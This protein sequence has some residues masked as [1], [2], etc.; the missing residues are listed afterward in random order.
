MNRSRRAWALLALG[1]WCVS[2]PSS[3]SMAEAQS[4]SR[5]IIAPGHWQVVAHLDP[6]GDLLTD[7][8][9]LVGYGDTL[10]VFDYGDFT[11]R[12]LDRGG[13]Q[14]W[15]AGR[16]GGGPGEFGNPMTIVAG[17]DGTIWVND[18]A[19]GR[20][21][22]FSRAGRFIDQV[23]VTEQLT[24]V[25]PF[26]NRGF[27]A[28]GNFE[29]G[30]LVQVYDSSGRMLRGIA[31]PDSLRSVPLIAREAIL[32][33][34]ER[35]ATISFRFSDLAYRVDLG[36]GTLREFRGPERVG[37]VKP[38]TASTTIDGKAYRISRA[39]PNAVK[40]STAVVGGQ[41]ATLR[42][43]FGGTTADSGRLIDEYDRSSGRYVGSRILPLHPV[44]VAEVKGDLAGIVMD[45]VPSI[46]IWRWVPASS[47][48]NR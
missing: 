5:R 26:R 1:L 35:A 29:S 25:L 27:A 6:N 38:I 13:R 33:G 18:P 15:A 45:P 8:Q 20:I 37:F 23:T 10:V 32:S 42:V 14:L 43:L 9:L 31:L 44:A 40:A 34:N 2:G 46:Y 11:L 39:N 19:N 24:S 30:N 3:S 47:G 21:S 41:G 17:P 22:R 12:A 28:L 48:G 36:T 16:R 7:P 4:A